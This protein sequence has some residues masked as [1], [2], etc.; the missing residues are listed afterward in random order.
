MLLP[1]GYQFGIDMGSDS[2]KSL[3]L[4]TGAF[5]Y[6]RSSSDIEWSIYVRAQYRPAPNVLV[7]VG[8]NLYKQTNPLQYI[9]AVPDTTGAAANTYGAHYIFGGLNQ[10]ELSAGNPLE[11]TDKSTVLPP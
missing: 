1:P 3:T 2:R 11:L 10:T 9:G 6:F 7:S 4:N 8:P 5:T